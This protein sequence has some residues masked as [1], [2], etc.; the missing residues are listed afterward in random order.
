MLAPDY[1]RQIEHIDHAITN[2]AVL[3]VIGVG[4]AAKLVE[5]LVRCGVR[6]V[7]ICDPDTVSATNLATQGYYPDQVGMPKVEA[8]EEILR[9]TEPGI[10]VRAFAARY[11]DIVP[12]EREEMWR[13][14][15]LMMAMTD[16]FE[17]QMAINSDALKFRVDTIFAM[18]G[19]GLRQMEITATFPEVVENGGGCHACHIWPRVKAYRNGFENK[20][21]IPSH[22]VSAD[23]LNAQL[24][25]LALSRLHLNAGSTR[26]IAEIARRFSASPCLLTQLDPTFWPENPDSYGSIA[27]EF[28]LFTTRL[29]AIDSP[30]GWICEACGT[31]GT[32]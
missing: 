26:P 16:H 5:H 7:W 10:T 18:M 30:K 29:F 21:V 32:K 8:L 17:T 25:Y 31:A 6:E 13:R 27:P 22:I 3:G 24:E 20:A 28:G 11:Q 12:Q 2:S 9:R 15:S 1:S 19:D 4:G 14:V 23:A